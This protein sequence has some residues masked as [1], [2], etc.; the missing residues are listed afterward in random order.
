MLDWLLFWSWTGWEFQR[1]KRKEHRLRKIWQ[2]Y[3]PKLRI[4]RLRCIWIR[5]VGE[6]M[7]FDSGP[8]V[9]TLVNRN[10]VLTEYVPN[11]NDCVKAALDKKP[12]LI[13]TQIAQKPHSYRS[14]SL[15]KAAK[16]G[17]CRTKSC[18]Y[19]HA[20]CLFKFEVV[21]EQSQCQVSLSFY[22][23][24]TAFTGFANSGFCT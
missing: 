17:R 21:V 10:Y 11:E 1:T 12:H 9:F 16:C 13:R 22:V 4:N 2:L 20:K 7:R 15:K 18:R 5:L 14:R 23:C 8:E 24:Q 3:K 6:S 19:S